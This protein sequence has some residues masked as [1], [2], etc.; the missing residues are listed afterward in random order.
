MTILTDVLIRKTAIRLDLISDSSVRFVRGIDESRNLYALD[1]AA[2]LL[3]ELADAKV[4][5]ETVTFG[6][7]I[8]NNSKIELTLERVNGLLGTSFTLDEVK[9][10]F[11]RLSFKYEETNKTTLLVSIPSYRKDIFDSEDLVE[12][13]IRL[14]GFDR[15]VSTYPVTSNV[16]SLSSEQSKRRLVRNH[17]LINGINEA[18]TYTLV[19]SKI[20]ED[21]NCLPISKLPSIEIL[22]PLTEEH[23]ILR[24]SLIPSLLEAVK[25]NNYHGND[26]ICL[27]ETS[28]IYCDNEK[29]KE[30]L[31]VVLQ[32]TNNRLEWNKNKNEAYNFYS[33]K[34]LLTGLFEKLG[35]DENRYQ[36]VRVENTNKFYHIGASC[37]IKVNNGFR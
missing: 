36:L 22:H 28:N 9:S 35:I 3:V 19:S 2:K 34:G 13:V 14:L 4:V 20:S 5:E 37:Y 1:L 10:V 25:Y 32:G 8:L 21:F 12:E 23:K 31:G 33:I 6:K 7:P 15:L 16:G 18:K 11:D 26:N 30:L 17:F 27:F 24:R 29:S